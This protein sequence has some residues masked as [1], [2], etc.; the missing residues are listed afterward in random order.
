MKY[1]FRPV[2]VLVHSEA[3]EDTMEQV[4]DACPE[5]Q[6][7]DFILNSKDEG[8]VTVDVVFERE[9]GAKWDYKTFRSKF[10]YSPEQWKIIEEYF[11]YTEQKI[12]TIQLILIKEKEYATK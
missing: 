11:D 9:D 3:N 5:I 2:R 4:M 10:D 8:L 1:S 7:I 12:A 6:N